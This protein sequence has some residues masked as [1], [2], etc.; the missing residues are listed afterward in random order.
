[1]CCYYADIGEYLYPLVYS[2]YFPIIRVWFL[3]FVANFLFFRNI[4]KKSKLLENTQN[5]KRMI[6]SGERIMKSVGMYRGCNKD[7]YHVFYNIFHIGGGIIWALSYIIFFEFILILFML[8]C[9]SLNKKK[10]FMK[11]MHCLYLF[12]CIPGLRGGSIEVD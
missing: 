4:T 8:I 11:I 9:F 12:N 7:I 1:M 2:I 5:M 10:F 3:S 6:N